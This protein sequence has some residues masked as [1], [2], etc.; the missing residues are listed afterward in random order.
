[1]P[2]MAI[3]APGGWLADDLRRNKL[4]SKDHQERLHNTAVL[5]ASMTSGTWSELS[6]TLR[7]STTTNA[8]IPGGGRTQGALS[9]RPNTVDAGA[10][11]ETK[12]G[13]HDPRAQAEY[14]RLGV[15]AEPRSWAWMM[16][17][18]RDHV[19]YGDD[20]VVN[21][22]DIQV[23]AVSGDGPEWAVGP[24]TLPGPYA[25]RKVPVRRCPVVEIDGQQMRIRAKTF[26][27]GESLST[28]EHLHE[29]QNPPTPARKEKAP[30]QTQEHKAR[31][32]SLHM[33]GVQTKPPFIPV[34]RD[35]RKQWSAYGG[36]AG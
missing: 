10:Y 30:A 33:G 13:W 20:G 1:M 11:D 9:M 6:S 17:K 16:R 36:R 4:K 18:A 26:E 35:Y 19:G 28:V 7:P 23:T 12:H 15:P 31:Y 25:T 34:M 32:C 29:S 21:W 24:R 22:G 8:R 2:G 27:R 14:A 3:S 5:S